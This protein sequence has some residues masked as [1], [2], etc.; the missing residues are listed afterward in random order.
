MDLTCD[1]HAINTRLTRDYD[2]RHP[3]V[4]AGM[5]FVAHPA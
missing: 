2:I 5:G 3:F 4:G 1:E